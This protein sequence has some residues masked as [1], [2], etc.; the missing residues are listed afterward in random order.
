MGLN[1]DLLYVVGYQGVMDLEEGKGEKQGIQA[2]SPFKTGPTIKKF[3]MFFF[4]LSGGCYFRVLV[5]Q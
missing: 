3:F 2:F 1:H 5:V 4:F